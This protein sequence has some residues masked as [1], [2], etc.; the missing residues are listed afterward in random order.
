MEIDKKHFKSVK[1]MLMTTAHP[2]L[3]FG[4]SL[5][6]LEPECALPLAEEKFV[7]LYYDYYIKP[8]QN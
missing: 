2:F 7:L 4:A 6:M 8:S 5:N 1:N 3:D